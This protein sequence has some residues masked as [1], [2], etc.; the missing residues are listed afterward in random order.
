MYARLKHEEGFKAEQIYDK[1][2][3]EG[4]SASKGRGQTRTTMHGMIKPTDSDWGWRHHVAPPHK[5]MS[6]DLRHAGRTHIA[7]PAVKRSQIAQFMTWSGLQLSKFID[8]A[9]VAC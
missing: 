2:G 1:S 6:F 8:R 3:Q 9:C 5:T 7:V 4:G